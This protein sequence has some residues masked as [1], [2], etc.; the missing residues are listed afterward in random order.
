ML[1]EEIIEDFGKYICDSDTIDYQKLSLIC[2]ETL[3]KQNET[4]NNLEIELNEIEN[5]LIDLEKI[6]SIQH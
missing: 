4:I 6:F 2:I 5:V 3:K 1:Y